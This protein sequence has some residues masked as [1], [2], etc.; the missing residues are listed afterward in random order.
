MSAV[1]VFLAVVIGFS[2]W[3]LYHQKVMEKPWLERGV[4]TALPETDVSGMPT[5]KIALAVFL[6]VVGSL[7]A[8]FASAYFMRMNYAD[9]Q[10]PPMPRLLWLNTGVLVMA[11]VALSCAVRAAR[12]GQRALVRLG[13][14]AAGLASL[15]FLAGQ[16]FAWHSLAAAG[17]YL[18]V[19]PANGF[20]YLLT[21]VHGLHILGGLVALARSMGRAWTREVPAERLRL[22][23]ELCAAYWHFLLFVWL[24]ILVLLAGWAGDL[25]ALCRQILA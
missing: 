23:V 1:L 25:I 24:G 8:L 5:A 9:W 15:V 16:L 22:G 17:H 4:H 20:F 11:S 18:D 12:D 10:A 13:L 6:A 19:N 21:G 2:F 7:F 3:W 14:A